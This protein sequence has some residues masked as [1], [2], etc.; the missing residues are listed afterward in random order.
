MDGDKKCGRRRLSA[1]VGAQMDDYGKK[2]NMS[3]HDHS[4]KKS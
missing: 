2:K 4:R 1:W 3:E